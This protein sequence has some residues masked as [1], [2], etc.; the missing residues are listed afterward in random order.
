MAHTIDGVEITDM[1]WT[2]MG[3]YMTTIE[4]GIKANYR[5]KYFLLSIIEP[6]AHSIMENG[7]EL[8][9][10]AA[11]SGVGDG[12]EDAAKEFFAKLP[13]RRA[14]LELQ[15]AKIEAWVA[16]M[17]QFFPD[18]QVESAPQEEE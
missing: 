5:Q 9:N 15:K 11:S 10:L 2:L 7:P 3:E 14:D 17:D 1:Q 12:L 16:L 6:V 4:A 18:R 13:E 8:D